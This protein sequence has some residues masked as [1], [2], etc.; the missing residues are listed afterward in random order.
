M[1]KC[2]IHFPVLKKERGNGEKAG[3]KEVAEPSG[4]V[5]NVYTSGNGQGAKDAGFTM[6]IM[7]DYR[8]YPYMRDTDNDA[9]V[10][11]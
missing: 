11:E 2:V 10:G 8:L 6:P 5:S 9:M 7:G 3:K 4:D 1:S